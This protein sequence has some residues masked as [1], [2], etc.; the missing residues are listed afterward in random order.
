MEFKIMN[1]LLK[2]FEEEFKG[3]DSL[4]EEMDQLYSN[5]EKELDELSETKFSIDKP[6]KTA[7]L[8]QELLEIE[9]EREKLKK[10]RNTAEISV[11]RLRKIGSEI[12]EEARAE[13]NKKVT[14]TLNSM[15]FSFEKCIVELREESNVL[16]QEMD[17]CIRKIRP[18]CDEESKAYINHLFIFYTPFDFVENEL[19]KFK[20]RI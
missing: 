1:E 20:R 15:M 6:K 7:A 4:K 19:A 10:K 12:T 9:K 2:E 5:L 3:L 11:N 16:K 14:E 18:Y 8:K 17:N 13:Y